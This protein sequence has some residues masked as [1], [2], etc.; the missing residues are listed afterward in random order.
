MRVVQGSPAAQFIE[1][2]SSDDPRRYGMG[3]GGL[4]EPILPGF[5]EPR[6]PRPDTGGITAALGII[7]NPRQGG[8]GQ[9]NSF[10]STPFPNNLTLP[11]ITMNQPTSQN[12]QN[13]LGGNFGQTTQ[14]SFGTSMGNQGGLKSL[15]DNYFN[16]YLNNYFQQNLK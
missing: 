13:P 9:I 11:G 6:Q 10:N 8:F 7:G 4:G 14:G 15:L 16:N 12:Q 3:F 2:L 1:T 5:D